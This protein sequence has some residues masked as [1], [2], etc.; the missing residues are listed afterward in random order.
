MGRRLAVLGCIFAAGGGSLAAAA[1]N[2]QV[3]YLQKSLKAN[4]VATFK[5]QAPSLKFTT[6]TCKLPADGVTAHCVAHFKVSGVSGYYP[7]TATILE[8]G[9][10]KWVA[11]SPQC[12]N[13]KTGKTAACNG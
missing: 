3:A 5:K 9:K 7:V 2:P 8:S 4:L 1:T 6:V 13:P 10:L 12:T 11:Q